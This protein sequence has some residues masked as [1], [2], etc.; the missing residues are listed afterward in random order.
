MSLTLVSEAFEPGNMIPSRYTCDDEDISPPLSWTGAP[1]N[2]GVFALTLELAIDGPDFLREVFVHWLLF[3]IPANVHQ[4]AAGIP[5]LPRLENGAV[6]ALND[7]DRIGYSG[8]LPTPGTA[9]PLSL[10]PLC[11]GSSVEPE[12]RRL[13]SAGV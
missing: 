4:L 6:Q 7:F 13:E 1:S 2:V 9:S 12:Q 11:T 10:H 3:N 8:P 5:T